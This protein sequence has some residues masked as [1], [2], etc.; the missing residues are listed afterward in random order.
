MIIMPMSIIVHTQECND[1]V[2]TIVNIVNIVITIMSI[3]IRIIM[4]IIISTS[5]ITFVVS[6]N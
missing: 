5:I 4:G 2:L 3:I 6:N 1:T